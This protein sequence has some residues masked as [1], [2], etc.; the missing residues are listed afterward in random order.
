MHLILPPLKAGMIVLADRYIYTAF[1]RDVVRGV[2][3]DWVRDIYGFAI[4]PDIA[5][6]FKVPIE[7]SLKRILNARVELKF[8]EA[9]M[10]LG[11]SPDIRESFRIFQSMVLK[12][13]D[14]IAKECNMIVVDASLSIKR[15][16]AI[17]R[18]VVEDCIRNYQPSNYYMKEDAAYAG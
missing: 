14:N 11:L 5:F 6:Y 13:Y 2:G 10:D 12:E 18:K 4:K 17:V 16:Q 7:V 15:Q 1:A 8:H 9:G 3:P